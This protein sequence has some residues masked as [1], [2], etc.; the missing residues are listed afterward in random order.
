MRIAY[1]PKYLARNGAP[2]LEA[3]LQGCRRHGIITEENSMTADAAVIWSQLWSGKMLPNQDIWRSYRARQATI[4]VLEV[5]MLQ[6]NHTWRLL[7]NGENRIHQTG[8]NNSRAASLGLELKPWRQHGQDIVIY[9][10]RQDSQQWRGMPETRTWALETVS[11]IRSVSDRPIKIRCH[12]RQRLDFG[13]L[14]Q[15][16]RALPGTYDDFD[17]DQSLDTAW[18]AVNWNSGPGVQSTIMGVPAFVGI[19]SIAAEVAN[20]DLA[21]IESPVKPDRTQWFNDIAH[22]EYTTDEIQQGLAWDYVSG[23]VP[24]P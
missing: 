2:V 9:L 14:S 24:I 19:N 18:A 13:N 16:P 8:H 10:Q 11:Q 3:F 17:F 4:L 7:V 20:T 23:L 1:F 5:G 12:P 6:R 21:M 15:F 22:T